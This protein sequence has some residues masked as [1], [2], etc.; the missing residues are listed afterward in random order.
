MRVEPHPERYSVS[1]AYRKLRAGDNRS[2]SCDGGS[3]EGG[4][5]ACSRRSVS[6]GM[7]ERNTLN[8]RLSVFDGDNACLALAVYR[9]PPEPLGDSFRRKVG[10]F[11]GKIGVRLEF[12][13]ARQNCLSGMFGGE[14]KVVRVGL[15]SKGRE[16]RLKRQIPERRKLRDIMVVRSASNSRVPKTGED[17]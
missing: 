15:A 12:P 10:C 5:V 2:D 17:R 1:E 4:A 13:T 16:P 7:S 14:A 6:N 9:P 11:A 3:N 8:S